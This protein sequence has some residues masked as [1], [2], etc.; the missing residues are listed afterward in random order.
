MI[1][2]MIVMKNGVCQ[3][4]SVYSYMIQRHTYHADACGR[5]TQVSSTE[6][7]SVTLIAEVQQIAKVNIT[8]HLLYILFT[9]EAWIQT[10]VYIVCGRWR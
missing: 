10:Y 3:H 8:G 9:N 1:F 6:E 4:I 5:R 2:K 7:T